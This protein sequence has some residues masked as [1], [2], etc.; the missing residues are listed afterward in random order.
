MRYL[1]FF[2]PLA[3]VGVSMHVARQFQN[4][5]LASYPNAKREL[6]TFAIAFSTFALFNAVLVF[7]PQMT[8]RLARSRGS[9]RRCRQF[10]LIVACGITACVAILSLTPP[11]AWVLRSVF[12]VSDEMLRPVIR[13]LRYFL[14]LPLIAASTQFYRGLLT[15]AERTGIVTILQVLRLT[16]VATI[17]ISGWELGWDPVVTLAMSQ[18]VS[19]FVHLAAAYVFRRLY[20]ALP[21][22]RGEERVGW[23]D[24]YRFFWPIAVTGVMLALSR[25]VLFAFLSRVEEGEAMIASL[26]VAFALA[27]MFHMPVNACRDLFVTFGTEDLAGV[28]RFTLRVTAVGFAAILLAT[29]TPLARLALQHLLNV[30]G[31]VLEMA[32]VTFWPLCFIPLAVMM[33][34]YYHGRAMIE[35]RTIGMG[36]GGISR[37]GTIIAGSAVLYALGWLNHLTAAALLAAGFAAE[38]IG[39]AVVVRMKREPV[40]VPEL[41]EPMD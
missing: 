35:R 29:A 10:T 11:G 28:R 36:I 20:Y 22:N 2:W 34:N 25:P 8:N 3:L 37:N 12:S 30:K 16:M 5:A 15:Q 27:M 4:R 31:E 18:V 6:A 23:R 9:Y 1:K 24:I 41:S 32:A 21:A 40:D 39:V 14:P 33:R 26:A 13:Y 17:L 7:V 38:A 19:G